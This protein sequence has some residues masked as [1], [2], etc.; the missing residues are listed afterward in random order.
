MLPHELVHDH[1][2]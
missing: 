2:V 1:A